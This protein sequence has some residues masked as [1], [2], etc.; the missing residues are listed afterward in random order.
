VTTYNTDTATTN[1]DK[2]VETLIR[3][4]LEQELLPT[5]PHL[6]SGFIKATFVKG[7]NATMR[8]LR[9]PYATPNTN[10][11]SV[12]A[13][14]QPWLTEGVAPDGEELSIG[15]EEFTAYQ[16][17][18]RWTITDKADMESS[19]DL[20]ERIAAV[21]ARNAA[22]TADLYVANVINAGTNV[23]YAGSGNLARTDVGSTDVL[24]G[25]VVRRAAA[26]L[27]AD[28]V[29]GFNGGAYK[30]IIHPA[31][32]FDFEEDDDVGGWLSVGQYSTPDKIMSGELGQ[33]AGVRF[34]QSTNAK[35]FAAGG[36]GGVDV[37]STF[38]SGPEAYAFGDWGKTTFHFVPFVAAPGNELAQVAS[39][40]WKGWFGSM[41]VDEAGAR[42]I[43]IESAS[44]L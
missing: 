31:V 8:F 21:C 38:I 40:G 36:A 17:G 15:Y 34:V 11:N 26:N 1:F 39:Y 2:T 14:T 23:L 22:D 25:S 12:V 19:L 28:N 29:P 5:L 20:M 35:K 44:G 30:G 4:Q 41:L 37:Y 18:R 9:V 13:G 27:K 42:Y 3:K 24:N 43:R 16:A 32:V 10:S 33:Y 7:T 6:S